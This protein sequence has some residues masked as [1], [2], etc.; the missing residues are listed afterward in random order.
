MRKS[1]TL[2]WGILIFITPGEFEV[3][4][5]HSAEACGICIFQSDPSATGKNLNTDLNVDVTGLPHQ[6]V[7]QPCYC[8]YYCAYESC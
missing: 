8:I 5:Y 1:L 7:Y 2:G 4:Q 3:S 6:K